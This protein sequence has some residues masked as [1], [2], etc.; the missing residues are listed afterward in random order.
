MLQ[1]L[2]LFAEQSVKFVQECKRYGFA[3]VSQLREAGVTEDHLAK[4]GIGPLRLRLQ[5]NT[6]LHSDLTLASEDYLA[7]CAEAIARGWTKEHPQFAPALVQEEELNV[8]AVSTG[9]RKGLERFVE[10]LTGSLLCELRLE[11]EEAIHRPH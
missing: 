7:Q 6:A 11:R 5:A 2:T 10:E 3:T 1:V 9:M 8:A 4:F